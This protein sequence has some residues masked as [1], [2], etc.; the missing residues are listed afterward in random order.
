[1]AVG[2]GG[3][4][5]GDLAGAGAVSHRRA[6]CESGEAVGDDG[7]RLSGVE[8]GA[9]AHPRRSRRRWGA[10]LTPTQIVVSESSPPEP[11]DDCSLLRAPNSTTLRFLLTADPRR[12]FLLDSAVY[13][14][15]THQKFVGGGSGTRIDVRGV[16]RERTWEFTEC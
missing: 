16:R 1:M 9:M 6:R 12:P 8:E 3:R 10:H 7:E 14:E 2:V 4:A 13:E 5:A 11:R 15:H